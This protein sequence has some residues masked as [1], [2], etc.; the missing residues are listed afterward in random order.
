[1]GGPIIKR[2]GPHIWP[3]LFYLLITLMFTYPGISNF[4]THAIGDCF[5][6]FQNVWNIW[7][8]KTALLELHQNP[9]FTDYLFHPHG[10]TLVFQ[11]MN[12]FNGILALPLLSVFN[13]ITT[14]NII[15]VASF[16]FTGYFM[17]LLA[18][19]LTKHR[20]A[21]LLAGL[22]FTFC[23]YHTAHALGHLQLVSMQFIPLFILYLFK[24][25]E[26]QKKRHR[27]LAA[28]FLILTALC[29]WYYL[30]FL[31]MFTGFYALYRW[32][33][34]EDSIRVII[35]TLTPVMALTFIALSPIFIG[36]ITAIASQDF[37]GSHPP[38]GF[39]AD[40]TSFFIPGQVQ[41]LGRFFTGITEVYGTLKEEYGN[42]IGYSVLFLAVFGFIK[43]RR[44]DRRITFL[45]ISAVIFFILS[46]GWNLHVLGHN[47][48]SFSLPYQWFYKYCF[49][50]QFT[51]V[52]ERFTVMMM[53]C[54]SLL[55]AIGLAL[56]LNRIRGYR[57][58]L[59]AAAAFILLL[60]EY[61]TFPFT[62]TQLPHSPFYDE[63]AADGLD[64][65]VVDIPSGPGSLY[66][67]TFHGKRLMAGYVTRPTVAAANFLADTPIINN[68]YSQS[69]ALNG[70]DTLP[71]DEVHRL[72][73]EACLRYNIG[74]II[75][76]RGMDWP[77]YHDLGFF[78]VYKDNHIHVFRHADLTLE[79]VSIPKKLIDTGF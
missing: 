57:F 56:I 55:A 43:M 48:K 63:M 3:I 61:S 23:P 66:S 58:R 1:M 20:I 29:S 78:E 26:T 73:A 6:T 64:Y 25:F 50:F 27:N 75:T 40:L 9:Y 30:F 53:F 11:T 45:G 67:Q 37:T 74:Y 69:L 34:K 39:S 44:T 49:F 41:T 31:L 16:V 51:G 22:I 72:A 60:V 24:S 18:Y 71:A 32:I 15:L 14:Y 21:S 13:L 42:Y 52:P 65:A 12:P 54:L 8:M 7:W 70:F 77:L 62:I 33:R 76:L 36:M 4:S 47:I 46:L 2:L 79:E 59:F 28:L 19:Y 38:Q 68:L 10:I 17:Y 35:K 5:D